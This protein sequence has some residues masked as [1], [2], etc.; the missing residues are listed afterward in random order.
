MEGTSKQSPTTMKRRTFLTALLTPLLP[1]EK[2]APVIVPKTPVTPPLKAFAFPLIRQVYP[3]LIASD[4]VKVQPL[5]D[6]QG[7]VF[8]MNYIKP[9]PTFVQSLRAWIRKQVA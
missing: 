2:L 1:V 8:Y 4:L 7:L 3:T 6:P 5:D 9:K